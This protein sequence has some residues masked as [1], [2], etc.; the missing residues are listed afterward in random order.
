MPSSISAIRRVRVTFQSSPESRTLTRLIQLL[1]RAM[2]TSFYGMEW[3]VQQSP[4]RPNTPSARILETCDPTTRRIVLYP[5]NH[6]PKD[7]PLEQ[8]TFH[9]LLH[10]TFIL[11]SEPSQERL[12]L[13]M[14]RLLWPRL[15]ATYRR[16]LR[17]L[18][19]DAE[20]RNGRKVD[21][22]RTR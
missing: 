13:A 8:T 16:W 9:A 3:K 19:R 5:N 1:L 21:R 6:K 15:P 2:H 20:E 4:N 18:V 17:R 11:S 10:T 12:V 7:G 14:E 22:A